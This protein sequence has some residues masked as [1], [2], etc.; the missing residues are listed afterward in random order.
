L[1]CTVLLPLSAPL[2]VWHLPA[3]DMTADRS[4]VQHLDVELVEHG[5]LSCVAP[6]L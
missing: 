1:D 4:A 6:A 5:E 2:R 3:A